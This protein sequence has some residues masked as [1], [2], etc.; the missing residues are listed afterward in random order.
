MIRERWWTRR[1]GCLELAVCVLSTLLRSHLR[2]PA[3]H[4]QPFVSAQRSDM[5]LLVLLVLIMVVELV[6]VVAH[7]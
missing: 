7:P 5:P 3:T 4:N 2:R 1:V 6:D